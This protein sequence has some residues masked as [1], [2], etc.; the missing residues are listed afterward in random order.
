MIT[1]KYRLI[2]NVNY[3]TL[4][5]TF[6]NRAECNDWV[7][8]NPIVVIEIESNGTATYSRLFGGAQ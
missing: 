1:L 5:K 4:T 6:A 7:S 3:P 8:T 2:G